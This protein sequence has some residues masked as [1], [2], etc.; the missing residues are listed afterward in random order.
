MNCDLSELDLERVREERLDAGNCRRFDSSPKSPIFK[1]YAR[2][3][4]VQ[5]MNSIPGSRAQTVP[6]V[7]HNI[8]S[9]NHVLK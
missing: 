7:S 9:I 5:T 2:P 1:L 6:P 4:E 3:T 8:P